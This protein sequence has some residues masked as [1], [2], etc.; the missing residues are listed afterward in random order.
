MNFCGLDVGTSG[1][2]AVVFDEQGTQLADAYRAYETEYDPDGLR[3]LDPCEI[4]KKTKEVIGEACAKAGKIDAL[5]AASFGEAFVMLD[6][7]DEPLHDIMIFTDPRGE[8]EFLRAARDIPH[9][10]IA[11]V[12]GLPFSPT[13]SISKLLYL[14]ER[15]AELYGRAK[16]VLFI[17]DYVGYMLSGSAA[18]DYSIASRSMLFDARSC[19]WSGEMMDRFGIDRGLFS[20][21][22]PAG[23]VIGT[24]SP[25]VAAELGVPETM[26]IVAGIHDQPA[27]AIGTGLAAGSVACSMGTSECLTPIFTGIFQPEAIMRNGLSSE[28]VW[29]NGKYCTLAYNPSCGVLVEWF[30]RTF[31]AAETE[32]SGPPFALFEANFPQKPTKLMVQPYITGSGTPYLDTHARFALTGA[33]LETT[34]FDL[35]RGILEGLALD[36]YLNLELL[37]AQGVHAESL[38]CVGGGSKSRPWLQVKADVMQLP[39]STPL[40]REA[41]ALGC[42]ALGAVALGVYGSVEEAAGSMTHIVDTLEPNG[43]HREFYKEKFE[44][45]RTLHTRLKSGG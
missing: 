41:G 24:V 12:C 33:G 40:C 25:K 11:R 3:G 16:R 6:E 21:P 14:K 29:E 22:V 43:E 32:K 5:A 39:V 44:E 19:T 1:V 45:Y 37:R 42:A 34:R 7:R 4:W 26:K 30:F 15:K 8:E 38:T 31:A 17:E 35:Y 36:Q 2:K 10:E 20:R 28:P 13:Y 9:G 18:V 23:T 27:S